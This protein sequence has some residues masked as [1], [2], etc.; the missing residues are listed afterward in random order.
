MLGDQSLALGAGGGGSAVVPATE[1]TPLSIQFTR[2]GH[3]SK[4]L[5]TLNEMRLSR[6]QC[7]ITLQVGAERLS[8]HKLILVANSPYFRAMF[9][10]S[11]S[12]GTQS[13]VEMH[14]ISFVALEL[15]VGYVSN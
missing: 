6:E 5:S 10:C 11:Y 12:E 8:A 7:D 9:S 2:S 1:T 3:Y 4:M 14:D 15:L 13:S